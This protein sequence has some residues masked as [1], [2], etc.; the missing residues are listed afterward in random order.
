MRNSA[1]ILS[2]VLAMMKIATIVLGLL[3]S[4]CSDGSKLADMVGTLGSANA[5]DCPGTVTAAATTAD[6][7]VT[8]AD[9]S[10]STPAAKPAT[11]AAAPAEA[12]DAATLSPAMRQAIRDAVREAVRDLAPAS[13]AVVADDAQAGAGAAEDAPVPATHH[14]R[15]SSPAASVSVRR[16]AATRSYDDHTNFSES[17]EPDEY[18][19]PASGQVLVPREGQSVLNGPHHEGVAPPNSTPIRVPANSGW[20]G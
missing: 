15:G 3:V 8:I 11:P 1:V 17:T 14:R 9:A 7:G 10:G 6:H 12:T 18:R 13:R 5:K 16:P 19:L 2:G 20:S 4:A